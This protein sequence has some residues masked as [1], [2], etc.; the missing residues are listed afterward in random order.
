LIHNHATPKNRKVN[1]QLGD[2]QMGTQWHDGSRKT[3]RPLSG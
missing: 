1:H 2:M 3:W